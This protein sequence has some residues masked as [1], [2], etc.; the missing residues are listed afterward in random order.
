MALTLAEVDDP[1][2]RASIE[3]FHDA[4]EDVLRKRNE[5]RGGADQRVLYNL[6]YHEM[7]RGRLSEGLRLR[8]AGRLAGVYGSPPVPG[9][10]ILRPEEDVTGKVVLLRLEGGFGDEMCYVRFA[11]VLAQRGAKVVV[12]ASRALW[13][14]FRRLKSAPLMVE[15]PEG[16]DADAWLPS[17]S[18]AW[19]L[20]YEWD[21]IPGRA[22]LRAGPEHK[23]RWSKA[24]AGDGFKVGIRWF[25]NPEFEHQQFRRFPP[26]PLFDLAKLDG[27]KVYSLQRDEGA[28]LLPLDSGV[29]D[30]AGRLRTWEDTAA[31]IE[32]LDL[33]ISSCTSVA[34]LAAAM[35]KPTW[36]IVPIM[37]Y[38][39]WTHPWGGETTPWYKSVRLFRQE[40]FG[41]WTAPLARVRE[42][43]PLPV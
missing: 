37:P 36:I 33:V 16:V 28:E 27:V 31:A 35:G 6:G 1:A 40:K 13:P 18:A 43:L 10:P 34:H 9:I 29:V 5:E 8:D 23:E 20:G 17:M 26:Q 11:D 14:L 2:L 30:L 39:T 41:D 19:V 21:T 42:A 38:D 22:Y 25:G 4:A 24:L 3:G 12:T 15:R 7:R 32:N